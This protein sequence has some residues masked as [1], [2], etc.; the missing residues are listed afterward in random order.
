MLVIWFVGGIVIA[1]LV[2]MCWCL[3][4]ASSKRDS[5]NWD[6]YDEWGKK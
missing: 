1:V 3:C 5:F 2:V 6:D 4:V